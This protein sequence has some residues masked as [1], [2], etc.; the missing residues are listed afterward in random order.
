MNQ[1]NKCNC[2]CG[3]GSD[4]QKINDANKKTLTIFWQRLIKEEVLPVLDAD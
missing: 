3:C 2:Q 4:P 1:N